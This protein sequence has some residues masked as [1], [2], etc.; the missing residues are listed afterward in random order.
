MTKAR[1]LFSKDRR[2]WRAA[3]LLAIVCGWWVAGSGWSQAPKESDVEAAYLFNFA[4]FMHAPA[5]V[6]DSFVICILGKSPLSS[7]LDAITANEQIDGRPLKVMSAATP[8][9]ARNCDIA[10]LSDSE[11]PRIDKDIAMLAGS[12]ALTVS[13]AG[14]FLQHGGMIQFA[15]VQN[16]VRFSVNLDAVNKEKITLSSELLKVAMSVNGTAGG[17][18]R[19]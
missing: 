16:R 10:F 9:N 12:N 14:G 7:T 15:L 13:N 4:K 11:G 5:H 8:D 2:R 18:V 19:P 17:E 1:I 6:P 3:P